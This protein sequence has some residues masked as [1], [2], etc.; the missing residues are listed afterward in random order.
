VGTCSSR[1]LVR[2]TTSAH[3]GR[4]VPCSR[5]GQARNLAHNS[6]QLQMAPPGTQGNML[7]VSRFTAAAYLLLAL[8]CYK[9]TTTTLLLDP[10]TLDPASMTLKACW[11][12][13]SPGTVS[14]TSKQHLLA[15]DRHQKC[16]CVCACVCLCV[17]IACRPVWRA[18]GSTASAQPSLAQRKAEEVAH[19]WLL[20][21]SPSSLS[22]CTLAVILHIVCDLSYKQHMCNFRAPIPEVV[23]LQCLALALAQCFAG[24]ACSSCHGDGP[25]GHRPLGMARAMAAPAAASGSAAAIADAEAGGADHDHE[26]SAYVSKYDV[27]DSNVVSMYARFEGLEGYSRIRAKALQTYAFSGRA[28]MTHIPWFNSKGQRTCFR[29]RM[30][31]R[32]SEDTM[33]Y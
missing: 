4:K 23:L 9:T 14:S 1:R 33:L 27:W 5:Q 20:S 19:T 11:A 10:W 2:Q 3:I 17:L 7:P 28:G 29:H 31:D 15:S 18:V 25:L 24:P 26:L 32:D 13:C 12:S 8:G 21:T 22:A 6:V 30:N 16:V